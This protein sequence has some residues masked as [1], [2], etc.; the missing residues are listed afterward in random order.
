MD[1]KNKTTFSDA[2][3]ASSLSLS[4]DFEYV[5]NGFGA[6]SELIDSAA[7]RIVEKYKDAF[8]ELAK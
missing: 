5:E 7:Q 1:L 8:L 6:E 3:E 2:M 4:N